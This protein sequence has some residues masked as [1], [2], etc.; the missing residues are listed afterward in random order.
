MKRTPA[1]IHTPARLL[2]A[3]LLLIL[4]GSFPVAAQTDLDLDNPLPNW[5]DHE[6]EV[7]DRGPALFYSAVT[8]PP[9][10]FRIPA[11]YEPVKAIVM[12]WSGYTSMLKDIA[13][14]AA[15]DGDA[16]VWAVRGPSSI[17]GVPAEKYVRMNFRLNTVWSR[18]YGPFGVIQGTP[19]KPTSLGIV[20]AVYR[21]Y[22]YRRYDD[23]VPT[24]IAENRNVDSYAMDLILDGG[25]LM[26][27]S[28]GNLFMTKRTY[29]WNRSKSKEEVDQMLKDYYRVH[30]V[31]AIDYAGYPG[32][33]ADGTGHI[34]MFVKL[35]D[36]NT[37][38]ITRTDDEP[39]K[40][41]CEKAVK[42]FSSRTAPNGEAYRI[43]RVKGW[44]GGSTWYTYTNSLIVNNVVIMPAYSSYEHDNIQAAEAYILGMPGVTVKMV[45]SDSSIHAG[46]S[47]HCVTQQVPV[48]N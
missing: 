18:D 40:T 31:H 48:N 19:A 14:V 16:E 33:P 43:I 44:E 45:N 3:A 38:M 34:D 4:L 39:F 41:A 12:G 32:S 7:D 47:I 21:H 28:T 8:P 1:C 11:E 9:E 22:S 30:T 13:R 17:S 10:N 46:G 29:L 5:I 27:D 24:R 25:N 26:V 2:L 42:F 6:R 37:V 20:D 15:T 35:L 23:Q 36:D